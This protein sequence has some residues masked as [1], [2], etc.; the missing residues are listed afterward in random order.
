MV[1][2]IE[3]ILYLFNSIIYLKLLNLSKIAYLSL[4]K[5][6]R[7]SSDIRIIDNDTLASSK[8]AITFG[9]SRTSGYK[10]IPHLHSFM[11]Q[12]FLYFSNQYEQVKGQ[13]K[14]Y[15]RPK[16]LRWRLHD[17]K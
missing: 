7:G 3:R 4:K 8:Y 16:H 5:K 15:L 2:V 13:S 1:T 17:Q 11:T 12:T 10:N 9:S 6:N 14:V